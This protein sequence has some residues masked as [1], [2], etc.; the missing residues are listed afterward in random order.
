MMD[1]AWHA[2]PPHP[3]IRYF[4]MCLAAC[5]GV[6]VL[7]ARRPGVGAWNFVVLALVTVLL[8]PLALEVLLGTLL[9]G[10]GLSL[11]Y[12]LERLLFLVVTLGVGVLNYVPTRR[13]LGALLLGAGCA[14]ELIADFV[15]DREM[16]ALSAAEY[17]SLAAWLVALTPWAAFGLG[18]RASGS[19]VDRLWSDFR[20]RFGL[21]WGLRVREQ[22]NRVAANAGWPVVLRWRGVEATPGAPMPDPALQAQMTATLLALLKRFGPP[23][24]TER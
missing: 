10:K 18:R 7:G 13:A 8:L 23:E 5:A 2:R 14:A 4:A 6:A 17:H 16:A 1:A 12:V 20:D 15:P 24:T 21:I 19:V 22:F 9:G 3:G 11:G